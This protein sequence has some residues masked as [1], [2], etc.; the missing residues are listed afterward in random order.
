VNLEELIEDA[1]ARSPLV[2]LGASAAAA[3]PPERLHTLLRA[4]KPRVV[5]V[6]DIGGTAAPPD[7]AGWLRGQLGMAGT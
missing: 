3:L 2:L 5:V 4:L 1:V 7:L 6:P